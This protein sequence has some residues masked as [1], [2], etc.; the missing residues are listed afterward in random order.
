M[1][2]PTKRHDS[3]IRLCEFTYQRHVQLTLLNCELIVNFIDY[4]RL[5][6]TTKI[7]EWKNVP[8][9]KWQQGTMRVSPGQS[10]SIKIKTAKYNRTLSSHIRS[11]PVIFCDVSSNWVK[12]PYHQ[13]EVAKKFFYITL[14]QKTIN[15]TGILTCKTEYLLC[16]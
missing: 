3:T 15:I 7:K 16:W 1:T 10:F 8:L 9:L 14:K 12:L 5:E 11:C 13:S 2:L 6:N 4:Q